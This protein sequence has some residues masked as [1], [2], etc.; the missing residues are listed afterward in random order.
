MQTYV[1]TQ[2]L[3]FFALTNLVRPKSSILPAWGK[4]IVFFLQMIRFIPPGLLQKGDSADDLD[5]LS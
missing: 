2:Q 5:N 4:E 3:T 1:E